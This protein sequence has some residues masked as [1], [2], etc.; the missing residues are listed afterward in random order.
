MKI[1]FH[2]RASDNKWLLGK[3]KGTLAIKVPYIDCVCV[4]FSHFPEP[5]P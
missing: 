4:G 3:K 2:F 5:Q 1:N